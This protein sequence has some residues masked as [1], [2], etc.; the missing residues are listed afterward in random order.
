MDGHADD[1]PPWLARPADAVQLPVQSFP[2]MPL[3]AAVASLAPG[4]AE[5]IVL[6]W[7]ARA[8]CSHPVEV[9]VLRDAPIEHAVPP[10][11]RIVRLGGDTGAL[12]AVGRNVAAS[13]N[14][15]IVCHLLRHAERARLRAAG[16]VPLPVLHNARAGWIE[17]A[18][19]LEP[20]PR[21]LVVSIAAARELREDGYR[22]SIDVVRHLPLVRPR[23]PQARRVWRTRWAVPPDAVVIGMTGGVKPQKAY[24]RALRAF[25]ALLARRD[26][27]LVILGGP[28]GRDGPRAWQA[29]LAQ[30]RLLGIEDRIRLPGFVPDAAACLPA[31]DCLL[32]SSRYEGLSIATLEAAAAG[33]PI[34]ASDVG[35]QREADAPGLTLLPFDAADAA[36]A[37]ALES[38]LGDR[39]ALPDWRGF[40]ADRL[41]TILGLPTACAPTPR[42]LF[43]TANLNAGGAQRSLVNLALALRDRM[44]L[45]IA[46]CGPSTADAFAIRLANAGVACLRTAESRDAFDQAE[47]LLRWIRTRPP[48]VVC[49]W[50]VDPK[51]KLLVMKRL[52]AGDGPRGIDVSPGDHA[53]DEMRACH[54]FQRWIT[55]GA[56]AYFRTLACLVRK[57]D[58]PLPQDVAARNRTIPNGVPVPARTRVA[59][60]RRAPRVVVSG[61][62]APTKFLVEIA[63]A[64]TLVRH[65]HPDATLHVLGTAEPRHA[66]YAAAL[67]DAVAAW[68]AGAVRFH[69]ACFDAPAQLADYD[70]AVVLGEHQGS[71]NAV[72]EALAAGLPVIANDSGGTRAL[73]RNGRTG[74]LL[75]DRDPLHLAEALRRLLDDPATAQRMGDAGRRHVERRFSMH[76]MVDAYH[77]LFSGT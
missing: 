21:V 23:D 74:L 31:F 1:A 51:V 44:P 28:V 10:G 76:R 29:L 39:P 19:Q 48:S 52:A 2:P 63:A 72:L 36:W 59:P 33:L 6:D 47:S 41:W 11:V 27:W 45:E 68:P 30:A 58:A 18:G 7:A 32:N 60:P 20:D 61:R 43:V 75:P 46:V 17:P 67:R 38:A 64:M 15:V 14:P 16:A 25:A 42:V 12:D 73:V 71:P 22:G 65:T 37:D 35:G 8:S 55:F 34:L 13:G 26:A 24:P 69:G 4:G 57:F 77:R 3:H 66:A 9:V 62:I 5:R 54:A 56:D 49:F 40:Q 50:N 70:I 53:F